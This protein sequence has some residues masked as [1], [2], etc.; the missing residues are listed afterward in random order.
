[1]C[2]FVLFLVI[3]GA[4]EHGNHYTLNLVYEHILERTAYNMTYGPFGGVKSKC[5]MYIV[6]PGHLTVC[7][8]ADPHNS[9][10]S[11]SSAFSEHFLHKQKKLSIIGDKATA[12]RPH[13]HK[14]QRD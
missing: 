8:G 6:Y 12:F 11:A 2:V 13:K 4:V 3:S 7:G 9:L 5:Y 10:M 1:M 14:S